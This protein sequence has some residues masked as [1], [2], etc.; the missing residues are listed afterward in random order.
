MPLSFRLTTCY[1]PEPKK[2]SGLGVERTSKLSS[3]WWVKGFTQTKFKLLIKDDRMRL[4]KTLLLN[5]ICI[6]AIMVAMDGTFAIGQ[7][8][9]GQMQ[10]TPATG[11]A[12]QGSAAQAG[13]NL[14]KAADAPTAEKPYKITS[15]IHL[16]KGTN[17]GY[18]V[19]Q[20]ELLKGSHV[21][22]LTQKGDVPPT[23]L[24]VAANEQMRVGTFSPDRPATVIEHDPDFKQRI[25]KHLNGVQFFAP[26]EIASG[27][28][29]AKFKVD[30]TF[31]GLVCSGNNC[32]PV[33]AHKFKGGFGGY[34]E[35]TAQK[36][37]APQTSGNLNR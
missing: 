37:Q 10:N 12:P 23:K 1:S 5:S 6:I 3:H 28:D 32:M 24:K 29:L 15:R 27:V 21:Y 20:V 7:T 4:V 35:R 14:K 34:Y 26:I 8:Q 22:S 2:L 9:N 13:A 11:F 30:V 31:D 25:E 16:R 33:T 19:V 17:R 18:L 36:Q